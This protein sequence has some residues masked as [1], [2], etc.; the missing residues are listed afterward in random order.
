MWH[1]ASEFAW[2]LTFA[3]VLSFDSP[4]ATSWSQR[5]LFVFRQTVLGYGRSVFCRGRPRAGGVGLLTWK[6]NKVYKS[7]MSFIVF[8]AWCSERGNLFIQSLLLLLFTGPTEENHI[9]CF[10]SDNDFLAIVCLTHHVV[11]CRCIKKLRKLHKRDPK[12]L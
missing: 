12:A 6:G 10:V 7:S 9:S 2:I 8:C 11:R 3:L 1:G 4:G 5:R